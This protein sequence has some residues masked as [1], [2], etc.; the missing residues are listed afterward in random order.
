MTRHAPSRTILF[1]L[2]VLGL[3][4][5]EAGVGEVREAPPEI[6]RPQLVPCPPIQS[7][8]SGVF[9]W[10]CTGH[11]RQG[12]GYYIVFVR[13]SGT[14]VLLKVPEGR[15]SFEFTP[16]TVGKWR[17]IVINTDRDGTKP[18]IESQPGFFEVFEEDESGK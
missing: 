16:D 17:W 5:W 6:C 1:V 12:K 2:L 11:S 4:S 3:G 10:T 18:D 8:Q 13:P 9:T 15:T 14:Y 7:G